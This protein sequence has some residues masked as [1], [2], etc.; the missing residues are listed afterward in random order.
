MINF[1]RIAAERAAVMVTVVIFLL[2]HPGIEPVTCFYAT[3]IYIVMKKR[4]FILT[5]NCRSENHRS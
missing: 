5:K 2:Q 3:K 1:G 4:S